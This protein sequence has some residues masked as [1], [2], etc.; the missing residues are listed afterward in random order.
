MG[1]G[2]TESAWIAGVKCADC[3]GHISV[4]IPIW[5]DGDELVP[6]V[7]RLITFPEVREVIVSAAEPA[8]GLRDRIEM[9][10]AIFV[11]SSKPNRGLQL[12]QG[13]QVASGDWLLFQ[14]ADTELT[15][16]HVAALA[17]VDALDTVGGAFYRKFDERHPRLRFLERAER[18]HSRK[19]G[20]LYGDQSIFVQRRHFLRLGG[21]APFPL[22][23]DVEFSAR[24]RRSGK[25]KLLDPPVRSCARMQIVQGAWKVSLRNLLFLILFRCGVPVEGLHSWYYSADRQPRKFLEAP[26]SAER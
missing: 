13:A 5:R 15:P 10:G 12:N 9:F 7:Q 18:W 8:A 24:L 14:H 2:G 25:I 11:E 4:I 23:E 3:F 6:L 16:A 19:F 1:V 21:F 17:K 20:S 26:R 22:M